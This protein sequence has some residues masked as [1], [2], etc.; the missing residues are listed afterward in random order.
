MFATLGALIVVDIGADRMKALYAA[1]IEDL[2]PGDFVRVECA[3]C[4]Q[5][6]LI[7]GSPL[8]QDLRLRPIMP[9]LDLK[10]RL[11][12]RQCD[13]KGKAVVSIRWALQA[14]I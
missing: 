2:G 5:E 4:G 11:R 12:C 9:V 13:A 14:T 7:P 6:T 10:Y 3:G 1:R 8:L